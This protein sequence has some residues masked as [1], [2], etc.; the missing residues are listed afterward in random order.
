MLVL[1]RYPG[2]SVMISTPAGTVQMMVHEVRGDKVRL[3]FSAPSQVCIDREEVHQRK[4]CDIARAELGG[5][6]GGA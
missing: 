5:E 6:G 3:A 2:E 4:M 1:S